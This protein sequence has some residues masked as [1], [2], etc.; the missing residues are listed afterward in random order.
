VDEYKSSEAY[1]ADLI[2]LISSGIKKE[3]KSLSEF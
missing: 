2:L 1:G 3:I